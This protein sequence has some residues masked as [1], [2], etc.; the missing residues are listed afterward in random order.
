MLFSIYIIVP[1]TVMNDMLR[2]LNNQSE[3]F[4]LLL[5]RKSDQGDIPPKNYLI[6]IVGINQSKAGN[7]LL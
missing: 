7:I 4:R 1:V 3:K 5:V 6:L 2:I